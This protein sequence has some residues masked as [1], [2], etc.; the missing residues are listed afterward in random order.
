MTGLN[1]A[2]VEKLA[3]DKATVEKNEWY[4]FFLQEVIK[5]VK[6]VQRHVGAMISDPIDAIRLE[7]GRL[8]G[9]NW[10]LD[11]P[12]KLMNEIIKNLEK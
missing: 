8:Q 2:Q 11:R 1:T 3:R 12:D 10:V 4:Q 7:Q 5:Q 6:S 9:L